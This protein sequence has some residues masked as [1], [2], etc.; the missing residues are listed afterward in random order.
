[1]PGKAAQ[2]ILDNDIQQP[3]QLLDEVATALTRAGMHDKAGKWVMYNLH[4]SP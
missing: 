1:M 2:V 3:L 4:S